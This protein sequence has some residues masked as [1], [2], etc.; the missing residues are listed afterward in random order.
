MFP[1]FNQLGIPVKFL[2]V[3]EDIIDLEPF[4]PNEYVDGLFGDHDKSHA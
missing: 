2:G 3:G 4:D 1:L